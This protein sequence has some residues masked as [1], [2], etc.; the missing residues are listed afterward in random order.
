MDL[1]ST[2]ESAAP[3]SR[4]PLSERRAPTEVPALGVAGVL[5]CAAAL[6]HGIG[7]AGVGNWLDWQ[8]WA[9][10]LALGLLAAWASRPKARARRTRT[11]LLILAL[12][13]AG[14]A[15]IAPV[16]ARSAAS[17]EAAAR[18][19]EWRV[20][21]VV[22]DHRHLGRRGEID[23]S[24]AAPASDAPGLAVESN[25]RAT[26][27]ALGDGDLIAI[28]PTAMERRWAR[29]R[30]LPREDRPLPRE[31]LADEIVRLR[32]GSAGRDL[33]GAAIL[34]DLRR[35]GVQRLDELG[36]KGEPA[37]SGLLSALLFGETG[38]LPQGIAD[39][40]TRTGTRHMLALSGLHVGILGVIIALPMARC[41]CAVAAFL[42]AL[43]GRTW[44][45]SPALPAAALALAF[46]P[47][48]GQGAP[49][50]RAAMALALASLAPR[51]RRRA[52]GLNLVG[53][54]MVAEI[55][56][57]PI[58]P[59]RAG[60]QL[61]YLATAALIAA[62][63]PASRRILGL[64]PGGGDV[65]PTWPSGRRR[66]PWLRVICLRGM[67]ATAIAL[68]TSIVASMATLP[69]VWTR[70]GEFSPVGMVATPLAFLPLVVLVV[71]GWAWLAVA[72]LPGS[73]ATAEL[74]DALLR[75]LAHA[76]ERM[77]ALLSWADGV[78]WSPLP[79]PDRSL[80]WLGGSSLLCLVGLR[81]AARRSALWL[82]LG[83]VGYGLA[84][85]P[86]TGLTT[87]MERPMARARGLEVHV[88]DVGNGTA[89]VVR[90]P[91]EPTWIVDAGS[92]DR[93][94]VARSA[95]APLLRS[96]DVG[97]LCISLSHDDSDHAGA[98]PW[99]VRRWPARAWVGPRPTLEEATGVDA[100]PLAGIRRIPLRPGVQRVT[101]R[102]AAL[103]ILAV[104]GGDFDSNESSSMLD[105]RWTPPKGAED[106]R[107]W[108]VILSG[109]AEGHGLAAMLHATGSTPA[110][111]EPG[112]VD[113]LLLPHHGSATRH[114]GWLLDH[115]QPREVWVSGSDPPVQ[116]EELERRGLPVRSTAEFGAFVWGPAPVDFAPD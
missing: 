111:L 40:F 88:L 49:A 97:R 53:V 95:V 14:R 51:F 19:G 73:W 69:V 104:H 15:G 113:A 17:P 9:M 25:L 74:Q 2:P 60:V 29:S 38:H 37:L 83:A 110:H 114:L 116:R 41:L 64:F 44:R 42:S 26:E 33:T 45:P 1:P 39:L 100:D 67:R 48:A 10:V 101:D 59:L 54:A 52:L 108:R 3:V 36:D 103:Q 106:G 6:G 63:S 62:A 23:W 21:R 50:A 57:D 66:S 109:D 5:S 80:L 27:G 94:G 43:T 68:G 93:V 65:R 75:A 4:E 7:L 98:L 96:L 90:A 99:I 70:F 56:F 16:A 12:A 35:S 46:I 58:A 82:R 22:R 32:P 11:W 13:A 79:L 30:D 78:P 31:P 107:T 115:L 18:A 72:A 85:L 61:S 112:P 28:L 86:D 91:G 102:R 24:L 20:G 105:V 47:L 92:R 84:L 55:A 76:A 81:G 34:R 71:G 8:N 89:V 77:L 87:G